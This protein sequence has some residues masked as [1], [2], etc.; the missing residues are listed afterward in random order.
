MGA[1]VAH[2]AGK[3]QL[4]VRAGVALRAGVFPLPVGALVALYAPAFPLPVG[5]GAAL[6]TDA[7]QFAV[8]APVAVRAVVFHL[9]VRTGAAVHAEVFHLAVRAAVALR[10][11]AFQLAVGARG[12]RDAVVFPLA[13]GASLCTHLSRT[14]TP[15]RRVLRSFPPRRT[16]LQFW[17]KPTKSQSLLFFEWPAIFFGSSQFSLNLSTPNHSPQHTPHRA[18][19]AML[20]LAIGVALYTTPPHIKFPGLAAVF[21][22]RSLLRKRKGNCGD[23]DNNDVTANEPST[24]VELRWD[25][26]T[27]TLNTKKTKNNNKGNTSDADTLN[28]RVI[29]QN[30][31]GK[32]RPGRLL[33]ILGPSGSGKTSLLNV[34][35]SQTPNEGNL[36]LSGS[37]FRN[38]VL[39]RDTKRGREASQI[40]SQAHR[41]KVAYVRQQDVFFSELTVRET[42]TLSAKMKSKSNGSSDSID[43]SVTATLRAVGLSECAD[44]RVGDQKKNAGGISGGERKRLALACELVGKYL[45]E[46]TV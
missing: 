39:V 45:Y 43:E 27:S 29:L 26:I 33:A 13:V 44:A 46:Q 42:L 7:F 16:S 1:R 12:A 2:R 9:A 28:S 31:S 17:E 6:R 37:L 23:N 11:V 21:L 40:A 22:V 20:D 3:F 10:T 14:T 4:P 24:G 35:A 41:K 25:N 18:D 5:A 19:P 38:D 8:G 15:A 36:T 32:A 34:L 30:V